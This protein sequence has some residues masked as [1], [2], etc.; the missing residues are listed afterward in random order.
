MSKQ[1]NDVPLKA[2]A[3]I[4]EHLEHDEL[5][6]YCECCSNRDANAIRQHVY[7]HVRALLHHLATVEDYAEWAESL[8][9]SHH[10]YM[11]QHGL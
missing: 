5:R 6:H 10:D 9:D 2:I 11:V 8:L 4:V 7:H 3:G 1:A